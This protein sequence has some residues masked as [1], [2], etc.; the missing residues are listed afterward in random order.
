MAFN[1]TRE[2]VTAWIDDNKTMAKNTFPV[3]EI[4][5]DLNDLE[6]VVNNLAI[7]K[8]KLFDVYSN[9]NTIKASTPLLVPRSHSAQFK[10]K[11][12]QVS[13]IAQNINSF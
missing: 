4:D 11:D 5:R 12:K 9:E 13:K 2:K 6:N 8:F 3:F 1:L 7:H 10:E